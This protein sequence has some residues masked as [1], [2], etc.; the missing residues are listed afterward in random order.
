MLFNVCLFSISCLWPRGPGAPRARP[1]RP[2]AWRRGAGSSTS[3]APMWRFVYKF[4]NYS[5]KITPACRE[6]PLNFT[7]LARVLLNKPGF[8]SEVIAG[9]SIVKSPYG[10][11]RSPRSRA[12]RPRQWAPRSTAPASSKRSDPNHDNNP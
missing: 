9:E 2:R 1:S 6:Q 12:R 11:P 5:F 4:A 7:P 8:S 10:A 3:A